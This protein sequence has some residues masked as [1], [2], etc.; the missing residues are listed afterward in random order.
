MVD[1]VAQS[2]EGQDLSS[3]EKI[4]TCVGAAEGC[5]L[6]LW[7]HTIKTPTLL[8]AVGVF[9]ERYFANQNAGNTAPLYFF[10][11]KAFTSGL[12]KALASF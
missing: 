1:S 6:L 5:D 3:Q 10:S 8:L 11:M 2:V 7:M 4:T 12:V 9:L